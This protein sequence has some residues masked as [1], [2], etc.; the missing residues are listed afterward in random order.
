MC[1]TVHDEA[2]ASSGSSREQS[3][4]ENYQGTSTPAEQEAL[5]EEMQRATGLEYDEVVALL[6]EYHS[7]GG[8]GEERT[9]GDGLGSAAA[10]RPAKAPAAK[11]TDS[12]AIEGSSTRRAMPPQVTFS[13]D[14]QAASGAQE[15]PPRHPRGLGTSQK[16]RSDALLDVLLTDIS[17][18]QTAAETERLE[19]ERVLA[20]RAEARRLARERNRDVLSAT[21]GEVPLP[22]SI[23]TRDKF[24]ERYEADR[25]LRR[26][27]KAEAAAKKQKAAVK[28][29]AE[30]QARG[31]LVNLALKRQIAS[32][33]YLSR[34]ADGTRDRLAPPIGESAN[35]AAGAVDLDADGL[36]VPRPLSPRT[37]AAMRRVGI[38]IR[39]DGTMV[40]PEEEENE[41]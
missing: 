20:E 17:R 1:K 19:A 40:M 4:D 10:T 22:Q 14:A 2:V 28:A 6:R 5:I 30:R 26:Q 15:E 3:D 8:A 29:A 33:R 34:K 7:T 41:G 23:T 35:A 39:D 32:G 36:P 18:S 37:I 16:Q 21:R 31:I 27:L 9:G 12:D 13:N 24:V 11:S 38:A 25:E